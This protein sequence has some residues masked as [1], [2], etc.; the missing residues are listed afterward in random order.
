MSVL[1]MKT[2]P[3]GARVYLVPSLPVWGDVSA[4]KV[5]MTGLGYLGFRMIIRHPDQ[6][7]V[8]LFDDLVLQDHLLGLDLPVALDQQIQ[9]QLTQM[10]QCPTQLTY[11]GQ[12]AAYSKPLIMGVLNVTPDS[13]SDGGAYTIVDAALNHARAMVAAGADILDIGGEST[14][15]GAKPVW[16]GDE[17]DRVVPVIKAIKSSPDLS[18]IPLSIDTRHSFVMTEAIK[19]GADIINDVS[20]LTYDGDSLA[21]AQASNAPIILMH[22]KGES[23]DEHAYDD[24]LLD[25]YDYLAARVAVCEAAGIDRQRLIL[26]PGIGFGKRVLEDNLILMNNLSLFHTLGCP[27]LLGASRKRFIGAITGVEQAQDR[28]SGSVTAAL[29][30]VMQGIQIVRVHDVGETKQAILMQQAFQDHSL[31]DQ[32][33][34]RAERL[35]YAD[36]WNGLDD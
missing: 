9:A 34:L 10:H 6:P 27:I 7:T 26:D 15:P 14:R 28:V 29:K 2:V 5:G 19:A 21:V 8:R 11:G 35:G 4:F 30:G 32:P 24:V 36:Q 23:K 22:S 1:T 20:A 18:H 33:G 12:T 13:F 17:A 31:M 3:E 16:E 25:V